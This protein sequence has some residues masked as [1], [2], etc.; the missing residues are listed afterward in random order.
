MKILDA[1]GN[2]YEMKSV[3]KFSRE[4]DIPLVHLLAIIEGIVDNWEGWRLG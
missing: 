2:S 4:H 1:R 3:E